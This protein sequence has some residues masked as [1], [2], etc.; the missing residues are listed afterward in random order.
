MLPFDDELDANASRI[1]NQT[2]HDKDDEES[3]GCESLNPEHPEFQPP[4]KRK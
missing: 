2:G 3:S 4:P 1:S